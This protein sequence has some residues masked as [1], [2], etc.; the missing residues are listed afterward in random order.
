MQYHGS[1]WIPE[2]NLQSSFTPLLSHP[3]KHNKNIL[4]MVKHTLH[5]NIRRV[6]S[7][8]GVPHTSIWHAVN[9]EGL[10]LYHIHPT[11]H[12]ELQDCNIMLSFCR[13][14]NAHLDLY[15]LV[16][17]TSEAQLTH[18]EVTVSEN[19]HEITACNFQKQF[20]C[21]VAFKIYDYQIDICGNTNL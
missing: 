6:S 12:L 7:Q 8:V 1:S 18:N 4:A 20:T 13:S 5:W 2:K 10:C 14:T 9:F 15:P 17:L 21:G 3:Y 16:L 11:Q 19:T